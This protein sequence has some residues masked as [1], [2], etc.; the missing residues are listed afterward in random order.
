MV[1]KMAKWEPFEVVSKHELSRSLK[2]LRINKPGYSWRSKPSTGL[3]G[4]F[5]FVRIERRR[6]K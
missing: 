5:A 1:K 4:M 2:A 3:A 6:K